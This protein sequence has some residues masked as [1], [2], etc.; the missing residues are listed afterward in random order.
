MK[1]III[2]LLAFLFCAVIFTSCS[3]AEWQFNEKHHWMVIQKESDTSFQPIINKGEHIDLNLDNK[4]DVCGYTT[5]SDVC[6]HIEGEYKSNED[7]HWREYTCG[8]SAPTTLEKHLDLDSDNYCDACGYNIHKHIDRNTDNLCDVCSVC[9]HVVTDTLYFDKNQ[10]R[11]EYLCGCK[12]LEL[13]EPHVDENNDNSCDKCNFIV[14]CEHTWSE[15]THW[16]IIAVDINVKHHVHCT[17]C[18]EI[19]IPDSEG[20]GET[21]TITVEGGLESYILNDIPTEARAGSII[22]LRIPTEP[23]N[24][25]YLYVEMNNLYVRSTCRDDTTITLAFIMPDDNVTLT[26]SMKDK[27]DYHFERF[28]A[29]LYYYLP[30]LYDLN[31]DDVVEVKMREH[32]TNTTYGT[33]DDVYTLNDKEDIADLIYKFKWLRCYDIQGFS[34]G[35]Y[36]PKQYFDFVLSD[37]T[38]YSFYVY[39]GFLNGSINIEY[40][41]SPNDYD[42]TQHSHTLYVGW[43]HGLVYDHS[44]SSKQI[45]C[46]NDA[47]KWEFVFVDEESFHQGEPTHSIKVNYTTLYVVD[48]NLF[49]YFNENEEKICCRLVNNN[50]YDMFAENAVYYNTLVDAFLAKNPELSTAY[51]YRFYGISETGAIMGRIISDEIEY[52]DYT[53]RYDRYPIDN[54]Q[55]IFVFYKNELYTLSE[56]Y[57]NGYITTN[58][59]KIMYNN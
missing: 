35:D 2:T 31:S 49:Y 39:C 9:L 30:W 23:S 29:F 11:K 57:K 15:E 58:D 1:K 59:I 41:P 54:P 42:S 47:N 37:G 51:L 48:G 50:F 28:P 56:A 38:V 25:K 21:F 34:P 45:A 36:A 8:C 7:G 18:G 20:T 26:M 46:L 16:G 14:D 55:Q 5:S 40:M 19:K 32:I 13:G 3:Y 44:A 12:D 22:T 52:E 43:G 53:G 4:C 24:D 10:H 6:E 27:A 33:V 17:I